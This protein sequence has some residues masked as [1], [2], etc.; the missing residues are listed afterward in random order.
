M[1]VDTDYIDRSLGL[2]RVGVGGLDDQALLPW[3][4]IEVRADGERTRPWAGAGFIATAGE[5]RRIGDP[6]NY[7]DPYHAVVRN[8]QDGR[9]ARATSEG[10][11]DERRDE[12]NVDARALGSSSVHGRA[13]YAVRRRSTFEGEG[14]HDPWRY[15]PIQLANPPRR[16]IYSVRAEEQGIDQ[17]RS[18][19]LVRRDLSRACDSAS[20]PQAAEETPVRVETARDRIEGT[21]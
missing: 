18:E 3:A 21:T 8:G 20:H 1:D 15:R 7:S 12:D 16:S 11:P 4:T 19:S 17:N 9:V 2:Q 13:Y 6:F 5:P 10:R 14:S